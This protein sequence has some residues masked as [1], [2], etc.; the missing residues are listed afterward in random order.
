MEEKM[1]FLFLHEESKADAI[2]HLRVILQYLLYA[3][4]N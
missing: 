4:C 2:L 1:V 3:L